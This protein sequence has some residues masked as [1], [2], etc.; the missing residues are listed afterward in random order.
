[1]P[2]PT[3]LESTFLAR[4][5]NAAILNMLAARRGGT[6]PEIATARKLLPHTVRA[7]ISR[8][9]SCGGADILRQHVRGRGLVYKLVGGVR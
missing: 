4:P 9:G 6:V 3:K 7:A 5:A 1:M 2:K 8:L